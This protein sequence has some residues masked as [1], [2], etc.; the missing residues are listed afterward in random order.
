MA[1]DSREE[2]PVP[3]ATAAVE[4]DTAERPETGKET[5]SG[6]GGG[7]A[8]KASYAGVA[9]D[10]PKLAIVHS[11]LNQEITDEQYA[12]IQGGLL[13]IVD[14]IPVGE[15]IPWFQETSCT[16]EL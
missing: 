11:G 2:G 15:F 10:L 1:S 6:G 7:G 13:E 8:E 16:E 9:S 12:L 3:K 14:G 5:E 4:G